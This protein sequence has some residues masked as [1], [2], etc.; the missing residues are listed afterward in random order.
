MWDEIKI[1]H[2]QTSTVQHFSWYVGLKSMHGSK[3]DPGARK[4]HTCPGDYKLHHILQNM[5]RFD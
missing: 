1:V 3:S 4:C 2:S 5:D